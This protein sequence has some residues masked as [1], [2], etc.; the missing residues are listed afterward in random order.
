MNELWGKFRTGSRYL[1]WLKID[2][3]TNWDIEILKQDF[4]ESKIFHPID[5][6]N[7]PNLV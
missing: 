5:W 1:S 3:P 6:L 7:G 2:V 4:L